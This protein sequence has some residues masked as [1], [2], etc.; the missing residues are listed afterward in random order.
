VGRARR[1][2]ALQRHGWARTRQLAAPPSGAAAR[3]RRG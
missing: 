2:L 1:I 3:P